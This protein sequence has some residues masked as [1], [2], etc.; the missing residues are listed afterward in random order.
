[1]PFYYD[2]SAL[3]AVQDAI[4]A[5]GGEISHNDLLT[6]LEKAGKMDAAKSLLAFGQNGMLKAT[7]KARPDAAPVLVYSLPG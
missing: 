4:K 1:M 5:A 7:V 2:E 6:A 3:P